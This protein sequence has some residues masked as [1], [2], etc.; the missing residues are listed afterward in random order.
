MSLL[1]RFFCFCFYSSDFFSVFFK[2]AHSFLIFSFRVVGAIDTHVGH[3]T[4][5]KLWDA[6]I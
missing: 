4:S 2:V 3:E 5:V 1:F 6:I